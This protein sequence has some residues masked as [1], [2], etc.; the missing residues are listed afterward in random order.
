MWTLNWILY[1]PIW[2]QLWF[3]F[4]S[5]I[6]E[7]ALQRNGCKKGIPTVSHFVATDQEKAAEPEPKAEPRARG[8]KPTVRPLLQLAVA[9]PRRR[10]SDEANDKVRY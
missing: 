3:C 7:P 5:N 8:E 2:K 4:R 6:N 1:E 9:K 10:A